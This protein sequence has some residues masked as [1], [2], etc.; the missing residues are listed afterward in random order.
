[1]F[2]SQRIIYLIRHHHSR[3]WLIALAAC[4]VLMVTQI[5]AALD[6]RKLEAS[7]LKMGGNAQDFAQWTA[8]IATNSD[9][10]TEQKLRK[11]N[12]FFNRK[13][14]F[15]DDMELWGQTDY[16]ATPMESLA[17]A[18][19]DCEDYVIA[20]YFALRNMN[21]PDAQLR[22][23]YVRA[24]VGGANSSV[25]QAHMVLAYYPDLEGEPVILDSLITEIRP[26]SRRADLFPVFSF[27]A[28]GVFASA[29]RN[30]PM[31]AGGA[32]RLTRWQNLLER[33]WKE[34]FE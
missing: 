17:H 8:L 10:P 31:G 3:L 34:G 4:C 7:F 22:L 24:L 26:A 1:M 5:S 21:V 23:V 32:S 16:W 13:I 33:A 12:E 20:K 18:K 30:A 11:V 19:G 2:L 6:A 27:N 28:Q 15:T 9:A 29:A 14:V 25:Q